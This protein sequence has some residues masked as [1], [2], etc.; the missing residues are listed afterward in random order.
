MTCGIYKL[1][2]P[3]G[4]FYIGKS[5][6]IEKRWRQHWEN[7]SKGKHTRA[8]QAEFE[9]YGDYT[10]E[11]MLECHEDHI[12]IVE[13]TY[14][15]WYSP[16]LNGT[17]GTDRMSRLE[18]MEHLPILM[19]YFNM[20]TLEH[21]VELHNGKGKIAKLK[22]DLLVKKSIHDELELEY[23]ASQAD[24]LGTEMQ[25]K[26]SS[27]ELTRQKETIDRYVEIISAREARI[28]TLYD[29][30]DRLAEQRSAE[31]IEKDTLGRLSGME[32]LYASSRKYTE[33][34]N[35]EL[36]ALNKECNEL[37][38]YKKLPWYKKIFA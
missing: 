32:D 12:D 22:E 13:E 27:E 20:S 37:W 15:S 3:S 4:N 33:A 18:N 29:E 23:E 25:L 2:F 6:D 10:Q 16:T 17:K 21:I 19:E 1:T 28:T 5:V 26:K 36:T 9:R 8:M 38:K 24:L 14:I 31:E 11:I 30:F 35:V 7:L 34:L